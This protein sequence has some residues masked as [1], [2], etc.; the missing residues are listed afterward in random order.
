MNRATSTVE[1]CHVGGRDERGEKGERDKEGLGEKA[2][3]RKDGRRQGDHYPSCQWTIETLA[4]FDTDEYLT[5]ARACH[6]HTSA[7]YVYFIF[8][9]SVV[10]LA[11]VARNT[12]Q[13][14]CALAR[15]ASR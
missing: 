5:S 3:G 1:S 6:I 2:R 11:L 4:I 10:L 15:I 13:L 14:F 8:T 7:I 12:L 9:I